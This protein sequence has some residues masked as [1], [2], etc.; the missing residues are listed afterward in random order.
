MATVT[1][2]TAERMQV[3]ENESIID[4]DIVGDDLILIRRDLTTINA[5]NV[6]G[7]QGIQGP[8]G[9]VEEAPTDGIP[10]VRSNGLW[11]PG[12]LAP[13]R[14]TLANLTANNP[15]VAVGR[16]AIATDASPRMFA[17]GDGSTT[18]SNLLKFRSRSTSL[19]TST[20]AVQV[21]SL[22]PNYVDRTTLTVTFTVTDIPWIVVGHE[23]TLS[24]P[25]TGAGPIIAL[26]DGNGA[27]QKIAYGAMSSTAYGGSFWGVVPDITEIINIPGTYTRK[28][29]VMNA[30]VS[31]LTFGI[32]GGYYT[33]Y[34]YARP[35]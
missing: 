24:A 33:S 9:P 10:Y 3:I 2:F 31:T 4:G 29:S 17:I 32:S 1:G 13:L 34:L 26:R 30:G 20:D 21:A 23:K 8:V 35:L 5:G 15:V 28:L 19:F 25:A 12:T 18:W 27:A 14:D 7:P 6:R 16:L 22:N 11:V